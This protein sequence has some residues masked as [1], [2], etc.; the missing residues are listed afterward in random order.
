M[1][2]V[3]RNGNIVHRPIHRREFK[4]YTALRKSSTVRIERHYFSDED[5]FNEM[6]TK[7]NTSDK[8]TKVLLIHT[9]TVFLY[10]KDDDECKEPQQ[11]LQ[12]QHQQ[13][14]HKQKQRKTKKVTHNFKSC[15]WLNVRMRFCSRCGDEEKSHPS[16]P[17]FVDTNE[18][19][20]WRTIFCLGCLG[21]LL[22][23][24]HDYNLEEFQ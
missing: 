14:K 23:C 22:K 6:L 11:P 9:K 3:D 16:E 20:S 21:Q 10:G 7:Y 2:S 12:Q 8:Q 18:V 13:M 24:H 5:T 19:T 17:Y 15:G 4:R 1:R